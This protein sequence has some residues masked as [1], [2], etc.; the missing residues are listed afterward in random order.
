M[1]IL[2]D[3]RSQFLGKYLDRFCRGILLPMLVSCSVH[4]YK[5]TY[6]FSDVGLGKNYLI[7]G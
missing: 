1:K 4:A 5:L 6:H 2:Y 3:L 7:F